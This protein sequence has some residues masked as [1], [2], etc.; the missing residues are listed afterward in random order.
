M[1]FTK[2]AASY[3]KGAPHR[4]KA[5]CGSEATVGSFAPHLI[6]RMTDILW[7]LGLDGNQSYK[8][9][10]LFPRSLGDRDESLH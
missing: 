2:A 1:S 4:R 5:R 7:L 6:P 8:I 10:R 3:V 9:L